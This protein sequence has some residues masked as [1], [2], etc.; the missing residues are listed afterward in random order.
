MREL[1]SEVGAWS[2]GG[3]ARVAPIRPCQGATGRDW[4]RFSINRAHLKTR[5]LSTELIQRRRSR[6]RS[7]TSEFAFPVNF[8][9][10]C[11]KV[12]VY[13]WSPICESNSKCQVPTDIMRAAG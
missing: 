8:V 2:E 7:P 12:K 13:F 6:F 10:S 3:C 5:L 4:P 11:L 1:V 9:P